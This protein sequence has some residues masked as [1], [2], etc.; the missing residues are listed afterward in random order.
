MKRLPTPSSVTA[1]RIHL[2]ACGPLFQPAAVDHDSG[3]LHPRDHARARPGRVALPVSNTSVHR[4]HPLESPE[5]MLPGAVEAWGGSLARTR[6]HSGRGRPSRESRLN[7]SSCSSRLH[8]LHVVLV[9]GGGAGITIELDSALITVGVSKAVVVAELLAQIAALI[10][11]A[12]ARLAPSV[13]CF[14]WAQTRFWCPYRD[15]SGHIGCASIARH[16]P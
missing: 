10:R 1:R 8:L 5:G 6:A 9:A 13:G 11:R 2:P 3:R 14:Q 4:F 15:I 12:S 7:A 16:P